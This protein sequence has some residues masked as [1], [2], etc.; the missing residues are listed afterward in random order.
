M[1]I[2][3]WCRRPGR[4]SRKSP[5]APGTY[6]CGPRGYGGRAGVAAGFA[7]AGGKKKGGVLVDGPLRAYPGTLLGRVGENGEAFLIGDRFDGAPERDGKLY[8]QIMSSPY[9]N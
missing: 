8:L 6:V 1:P 9:D 2:R 4:A 3:P 7:L 5:S